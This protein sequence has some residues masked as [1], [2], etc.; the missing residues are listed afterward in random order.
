MQT[1]PLSDR[2]VLIT[3]V[4]SGIG[5]ALTTHLIGAGA[6]VLGVGRDA[7]RLSA[8]AEGWGERFTPVLADLS[9]PED[10]LR[11]IAAAR[12]AGVDALVNNAGACVYARP[13]AFSMDRWRAL[14]E[15]NLLA[16]IELSSALGADMGAGGQILNVSSV[17]ARHVAHPRFGPYAVTKA[18][19]EH[20]TESLRLELSPKGVAVSLLVPGLVDTPIYQKVEGF[21]R[22]EARLREALPEWLTPQD[23]AESAAWMLSQPEHVVISELVILPRGQAR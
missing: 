13:T 22:A 18:A 11:C 6:R 19:L 17:T 10:R 21:E 23:V 14:L 16:A 20:F 12:E 7:E 9:S 8:V 4:T 5:R 1:R 15:V 2:S 3:G